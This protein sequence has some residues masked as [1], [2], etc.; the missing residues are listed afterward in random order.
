MRCVMPSQFSRRVF[1]WVAVTFVLATFAGSSVA[2]GQSGTQLFNGWTITPAGT[3]I[4]LDHLEVVVQD[5]E[6]HKPAGGMS[7]D[8]P[9][10]MIISP[11]GKVL[12]AACAGYN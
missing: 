9:L 2:S 8:L 4:P 6:F 10:K 7:S 11:D 1:G 5:P 12:L 3:M